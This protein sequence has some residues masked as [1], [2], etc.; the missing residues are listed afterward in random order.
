[1]DANIVFFTAILATLQ[2][3]LSLFRYSVVLAEADERR[4]GSRAD[5]R[6]SILIFGEL[7]PIPRC[8]LPMTTP[9]D[10]GTSDALYVWSTML[11]V[12]W[13]ILLL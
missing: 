2:Q 11:A 9:H 3:K 6:F 13:A 8:L 10:Y 5:F 7:A 1:M 12:N 4:N